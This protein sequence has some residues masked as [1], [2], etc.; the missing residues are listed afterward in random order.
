MNISCECGRVPAGFS[1]HEGMQS[2]SFLG[3]STPLLPPSSLLPA[4]PALP[5]IF[6]EVKTAAVLV[7]FFSVEAVS[8]LESLEAH[9]QDRAAL[10]VSGSHLVCMS[11]GFCWMWLQDQDGICKNRSSH[12]THCCTVFFYSMFFPSAYQIAIHP[13][14]RLHLQHFLWLLQ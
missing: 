11:F 4:I 9:S 10:H 8:E 14:P 3:F 5:L 13:V 1:S 2:F 6:H 12:L 7:V